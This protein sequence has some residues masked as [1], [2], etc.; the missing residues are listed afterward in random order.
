MAKEK[1]QGGILKMQP[2]GLQMK[3]KV[4]F[5]IPTAFLLCLKNSEAS[6]LPSSGT[7]TAVSNITA[8]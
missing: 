2:I 6:D 4:F 8:Y 3:T 1:H 5:F 7:K